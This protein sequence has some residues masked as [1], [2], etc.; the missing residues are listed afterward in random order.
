MPI[1]LF[2]VNFIY[3]QDQ[4]Y[5][6][7]LSRITFICNLRWFMYSLDLLFDLWITLMCCLDQVYV[8][9]GSGYVFQDYVYILIY[10][11]DQ[12]TFFSGLTISSIVWISFMCRLESFSW[13]VWIT[14]MHSLDLLACCMDHFL[15]SS[16][17]CL[18]H[19]QLWPCSCPLN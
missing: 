18:D 19:V 3:P 6:H 15:N 4:V 13:A 2:Q 9:S 5:V 1:S 14:L 7:L 8:I 16:I 10:N 11:L 12:D 17:C